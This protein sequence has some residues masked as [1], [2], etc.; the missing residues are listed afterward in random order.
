[1]LDK[2]K[3]NEI[4]RDLVEGL[5]GFVQQLGTD[6]PMLNRVSWRPKIKL[7]F[8][9]PESERK[10]LGFLAGRFSFKTFHDGSTLVPETALSHLALAG[11]RFTVEGR[12]T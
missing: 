10:A 12:A 9:D 8:P 5:E 3:L 4:E 1:M 7:R 2:S 6:E 11:L